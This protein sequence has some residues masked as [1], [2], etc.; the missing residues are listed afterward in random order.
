MITTEPKSSLALFV[1]TL[2]VSATIGYSCERPASN[3]GPTPI[4]F[5]SIDVES[6]GHSDSIKA[7]GFDEYVQRYGRAGWL[8]GL[9]DSRSALEAMGEGA[10]AAKQKGGRQEGEDDSELRVKDV[11]YFYYVHDR[12]DTE[13]DIRWIPNARHKERDVVIGRIIKR[14]QNEK[15]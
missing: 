2:F 1:L 14:I 15:K 13:K 8:C 11:F 12:R 6:L 9:R 7:G 10:G 3:G 5:T 4:V